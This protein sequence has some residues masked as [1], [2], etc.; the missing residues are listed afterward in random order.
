MMTTT[1]PPDC[2]CSTCVRYRD[3]TG[4]AQRK[5]TSPAHI[6]DGDN[7]RTPRPTLAPRPID[8]FDSWRRRRLP[9]RL[10]GLA[11]GA[12]IAVAALYLARAVA[13]HVDQ[14]GSGLFTGIVRGA[15]PTLVA[16][17]FLRT[18]AYRRRDALLIFFVPLV[19]VWLLALIGWRLPVARH[20]DWPLRPTRCIPDDRR[21]SPP[22]TT[23]PANT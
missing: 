6:E 10:T 16:L 19:G 4:A 2:R 13:D 5:D 9:M 22:V 12:M 21:S 3:I 18:V 14:P 20:P 7:R 11:I 23:D 15:V 8:P 1:V 17:P